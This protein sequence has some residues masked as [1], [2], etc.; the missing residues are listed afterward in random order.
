MH[1]KPQ[2]SQNPSFTDYHSQS[3][4]H[5]VTNGSFRQRL[6]EE[7]ANDPD[8]LKIR[9]QVLGKEEAVSPAYT[10][11]DGMLFYKSRFVVPNSEELKKDILREEHDS[12]VAR[13]YGQYKTMER[14]TANFYWK[15]MDVWIED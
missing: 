3:I 7:V 12:R 11:E 10:V 5:A 15:N 4:T 2:Q 9:T 8:Y 13:H 1:A 14:V 6:L